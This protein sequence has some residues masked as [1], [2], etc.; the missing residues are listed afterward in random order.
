M[1]CMALWSLSLLPLILLLFSGLSDQWTVGPMDCRTNGLLNHWTVWLLEICHCCH[2]PCCYSVDCRT[3]GLSDR[4]TVGTMDRRTIGLCGSWKFVTVAIHPA[5]IQWTVGPMD[6]RTNGLC[7]S[8]KFV[9]LLL[10]SGLSYQ[11]TVRPMDCR[12][13]GLS[14][15]WTVAAMDCRTNGLSD[16]WTVGPKD[17]RTSG[18]TPQR[19]C[20]RSMSAAGYRDYRSK[21]LIGRSVL[22]VLWCCAL[23]RNLQRKSKNIHNG[24]R[25]IT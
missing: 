1:D 11:W 17:C 16:Q 2:S 25:P 18:L 13:N 24:R 14:D 8:W 5:A 6:C 10:F 12:T 20:Y 21:L 4:W 9:T 3:N 19:V 15:Q 22:C 23:Q 7:G